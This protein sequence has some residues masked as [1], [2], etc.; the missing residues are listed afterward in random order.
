MLFNN[1]SSLALIL[2]FATTEGG[3][4]RLH[5]AFHYRKLDII[6]LLLERGADVILGDEMHSRTP[7]HRS[8]LVYGSQFCSRTYQYGVQ[9]WMLVIVR[10]VSS[11]GTRASRDGNL[12]I[13]QLLLQRGRRREYVRI[14][15][16]STP[17]HEA[18][19]QRSISMSFEQ[20]IDFGRRDKRKE[21]WLARSP[22]YSRSGRRRGKLLSIAFAFYSRRAQTQIP[23]TSAVIPPLHVASTVGCVDV[24]NLL[25][26]RGC[27][28]ECSKKSTSRPHYSLSKRQ[29]DPQTRL[30][31]LLER[32]A[33]VDTRNELG[34]RRAH[35]SV[36]QCGIRES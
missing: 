12:G 28:R 11:V 24:V 23:G 29:A 13:V 14:T 15:S 30:R 17:L 33:D 19:G 25:L 3:H 31:C 6:L 4:S 1:L 32:G 18:V 2:I 36:W 26:D 22:R 20:L 34:A 16:K 10:G 21:R 7:L 5:K 8:F 35:F 9:M 27:Q